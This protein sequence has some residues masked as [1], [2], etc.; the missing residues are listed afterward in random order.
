MPAVRGSRVQAKPRAKAPAAREPAR[1][2]KTAAQAGAS[3]SPKIILIGAAAALVLGTIVAL[4]TGGRGE[5]LIAGVGHGIDN[6]FGQAGFR[7][8]TVHVQGASAMATAD[9]VKVTQYLTRDEDNAK[10]AKVRPHVL[11]V[12]EPASMLLVIP[13]LVPPEFLLE[14]EVIAAAKEQ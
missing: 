14:L 3:V 12:A 8:K 5:M 1:R 2:G 9:I 7:L 13:Q 6:R 4:A 11:G 10:Y